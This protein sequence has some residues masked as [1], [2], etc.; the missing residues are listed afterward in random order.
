MS[1][2]VTKK[3]QADRACRFHRNFTPLLHFF[4]AVREELA[5]ELAAA[6]NTI[7]IHHVEMPFENGLH[8]AF[9]DL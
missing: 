8:H 5:L 3:V 1:K 4:T 2:Y 6:L 7:V 9:G